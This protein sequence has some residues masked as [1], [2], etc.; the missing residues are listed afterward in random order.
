MFYHDEPLVDSNKLLIKQ[1]A[2][3]KD[4]AQSDSGRGFTVPGM[5]MNCWLDIS[6][7]KIDSYVKRLEKDIESEQATVR[8]LQQRLNNPGYLSNAP[9]DLVDMSREELNDAEQRMDNFLQEKL[10]YKGI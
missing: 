9:K 1:M 8:R 3:L 2:R 4:V 7:D 10:R 6:Q 5:T